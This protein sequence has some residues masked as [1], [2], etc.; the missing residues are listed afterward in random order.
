MN[1][2]YGGCER[3]VQPVRAWIMGLLLAWAG[4]AWPGFAIASNGPAGNGSAGGGPVGIASARPASAAAA[5][6][7][8]TRTLLVLGDSLSA[9]YG[10]AAN[11]GWVSLAAVRMRTTHPTWRVVNAS[12]SGDTTA[13]GAS[14]IARE[15]KR[16]RPAVVVIELGANDGL[17]GLELVHSRDNLERMITQ[18]TDSGARVL[19]VGMHLPPNF[20]PQYTK[21]FDAMYAGLAK[22]HQVAFLPFLLAPVADDRRNFQADNMHPVAAVQGRLRDHVWSALAPLLK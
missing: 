6:Q 9:G 1:Q 10:L 5:R 21:G 20:G 4:L 3:R 13:G 16:V 12:V 11:Q 22:S 15:L 7:A 8:T 17:R 18:S 2:G 19:L 14:R